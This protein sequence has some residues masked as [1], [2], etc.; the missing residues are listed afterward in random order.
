M[1]NTDMSVLRNIWNNIL[2]SNWL[3]WVHQRRHYWY[4]QRCII[5]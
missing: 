2:V 5:L 3:S 4:E 1:K